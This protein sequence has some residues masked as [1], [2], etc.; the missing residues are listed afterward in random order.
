M[1]IGITDAFRWGEESAPQRSSCAD[2]SAAL[3]AVA[4]ER[5]DAAKLEGRNPGSCTCHGEWPVTRAEHLRGFAKGLLGGRVLLRLSRARVIGALLG[6]Q[7]DGRHAQ[8]RNA[9]PHPA[10]WP[11]VRHSIF[12]GVVEPNT[13]PSTYAWH[14]STQPPVPARAGFRR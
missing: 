14:L 13:L 2:D 10:R 5:M 6:L 3:L 7:D 8:G 1:S 11:P 12:F 4:D 9:G